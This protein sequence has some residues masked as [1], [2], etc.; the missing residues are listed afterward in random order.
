MTME[1]TIFDKYIIRCLVKEFMHVGAKLSMGEVFDKSP[2][3]SYSNFTKGTS[4]PLTVS[5]T[6]VS[7][8]PQDKV[9]EDDSSSEPKSY[10]TKVPLTSVPMS[11]QVK[12]VKVPKPVDKR[13][14]LVQKSLFRS[15]LSHFLGRFRAWLK[16]S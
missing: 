6:L 13:G 15:V 14:M 16:F 4:E 1:T 10:K 12:A 7:L 9:S 2:S 3:E 8:E 11:T 5:G